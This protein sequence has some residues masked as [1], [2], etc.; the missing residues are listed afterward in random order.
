[1]WLDSWVLRLV[2]RRVALA[3]VSFVSPGGAAAKTG[4]VK[5][6]DAIAAVN[7]ESTL[8]LD[9]GGFDPNRPDAP[10]PGLPGGR[11][12][13]EFPCLTGTA[14]LGAD[15]LE[16]VQSRRDRIVHAK[17]GNYLHTVLRI[18]NA[19][20]TRRAGARRT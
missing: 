4:Q 20:N 7:G 1:M 9:D 8:Q 11:L 12:T 16:H 15:D 10:A 18:S 2:A 13:T 19:T 3:Q 6:G 5:E 17:P 14:E